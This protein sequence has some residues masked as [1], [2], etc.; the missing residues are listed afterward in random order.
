VEP[1][2]AT[3]PEQRLGDEPFVPLALITH[4][5]LDGCAYALHPQ[6]GLLRSDDG[7]RTWRV[8]LEPLTALRGSG[9]AF[10]T[11]ERPLL[12]V[13]GTPGWVFADRDDAFFP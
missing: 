1:P 6:R 3:L 11:G 10:T 8:G 9:L 12:L 5:T 2:A 7:G 13:L 4:P